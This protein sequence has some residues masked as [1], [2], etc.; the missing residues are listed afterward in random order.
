[1]IQKAALKALV[2]WHSKNTHTHKS[3]VKKQTNFIET[4]KLSELR[5]VR[6][7]H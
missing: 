3:K 4:V 6:N 7:P 5:Q 1:M 2:K